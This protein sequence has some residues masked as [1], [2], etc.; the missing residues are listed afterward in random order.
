MEETLRL[1]VGMRPKL[2]RVQNDDDHMLMCKRFAEG[3]CL[4][5]AYMFIHIRCFVIRLWRTMIII[6][7]CQ[8]LLRSFR[9]KKSHMSIYVHK[10]HFIVLEELGYPCT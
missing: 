10:L 9:W 3:K 6:A 1:A 2:L 7:K 5:W 4:T 8:I